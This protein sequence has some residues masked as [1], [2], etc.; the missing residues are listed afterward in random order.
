MAIVNGYCTLTE[1]KA[2]LGVTVSTYDTILEN[3]VEAVSRQFDAWCKRR[4]FTTSN[5]EDRYY[6][7]N[8]NQHVR[9]DDIVSITSLAT[10]ENGDR[11]YERT[12]A[13]TDYDL[14]PYNAALDSL[15]YNRIEVSPLGRYRFPLHS[16]AIKLS[17]KFG[18]ATTPD[19]VNE[20][21]L[22]QT[23]RIYRRK[24]S[25]FG[26][27]GTPEFGQLRLLA[28]L[29]PDVEAMLVGYRKILVA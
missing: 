23:E 26:V 4:F 27:A 6:D 21:C 22:I 18:F 7:A 24:D 8:T 1:I 2:R 12:W 9:T 5:D 13:S 28:R 15:P 25:P 19:S 10:D 11:V 3:V 20:A 16:K 17:G 29:D 14:L